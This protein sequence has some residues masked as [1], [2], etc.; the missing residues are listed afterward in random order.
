M[1][2]VKIPVE[3]ITTIK[4]AIARQTAS[5]SVNFQI[6][7]MHKIVLATS[8]IVITVKE[9]LR[10]TRGSMTPFNSFGGFDGCALFSS[11]I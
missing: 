1:T 11:S 6:A 5:D 10:T 8:E 9:I 7:K 2:K 4:V 3:T